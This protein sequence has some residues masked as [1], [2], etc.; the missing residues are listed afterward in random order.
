MQTN[1]LSINRKDSVV[2]VMDTVYFFTRYNVRYD[3]SAYVCCIR[4]RSR[5]NDHAGD[6]IFAIHKEVIRPFQVR[7]NL[8]AEWDERTVIELCSQSEG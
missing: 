1:N 7:G 4:S 6:A 3:E 5:Q 2:R 8:C